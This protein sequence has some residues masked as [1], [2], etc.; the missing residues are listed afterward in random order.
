VKLKTRLLTGIP[1]ACRPCPEEIL[2]PGKPVNDDI[3]KRLSAACQP[4]KRK[5]LTAGWGRPR[6]R[7]FLDI[8]SK[9]SNLVLQLMIGEPYIFCSPCAIQQAVLQLAEHQIL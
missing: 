6:N 9:K 8:K 4:R 2:L 3:P 5:A 7:I 1:D